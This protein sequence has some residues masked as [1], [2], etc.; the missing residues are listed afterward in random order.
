[1]G[2]NRDGERIVGHPDIT[3]FSSSVRLAGD[4]TA[5]LS[6]AVQSFNSILL[7]V[8]H[9]PGFFGFIEARQRTVAF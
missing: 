7:K 4:P 3:R 9:D 6:P 2:P 1:V 8:G 5:T